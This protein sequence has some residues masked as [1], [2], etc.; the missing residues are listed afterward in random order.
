M[1][2]QKPHLSLVAQLGVARKAEI[3]AERVNARQGSACLPGEVS[4]LLL[5]C[6]TNTGDKVSLLVL[7]A[8]VRGETVAGDSHE[9]FLKP[10]RK[11]GGKNIPSVDF[12]TCLIT[13]LSNLFRPVLLT[14][15]LII[16][17]EDFPIWVAV[18]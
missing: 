14:K 18:F 5:V 6:S 17:H 2:V 1:A 15:Q 3:M 11:Q 4:A 13:T 10:P 7:E 8:L 9:M 12:A 16:C